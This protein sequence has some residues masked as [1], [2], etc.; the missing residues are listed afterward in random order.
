MKTIS[1]GFIVAT[2]ALATLFSTMLLWQNPSLLMFVL[3]LVAIALIIHMREKRMIAIYFFG[4]F[5]GPVTE[6]ASI[7]TG[8]WQY[9][10]PVIFG[11]PLWLPFVWGCA[12]VVIASAHSILSRKETPGTSRWFS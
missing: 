12:S 8:A 4:F 1:N 3:A 9:A 6:V 10:T 2:A 11:I 7:Y 5:L